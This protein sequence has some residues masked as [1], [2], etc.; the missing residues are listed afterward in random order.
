MFYPIIWSFLEDV[1]CALENVYSVAVEWHV[2]LYLFSSK[3]WFNANIDLLIFCL[4]IIFIADNRVLKSP[5]ITVLS[6]SLLKFIII[7]LIYFNA[8]AF[9]TYNIYDWLIHLCDVFTSLSL[10]ND[11]LW[12]MLPFWLDVCFVWYKDSCHVL[13]SICLEYHMPSFHLSLYVFSEL[14]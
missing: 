14:K 6:F 1:L 13:I 2:L 7:C 10:P 8:W 5:N 9:G 4:T 11:L 12:L 3:M